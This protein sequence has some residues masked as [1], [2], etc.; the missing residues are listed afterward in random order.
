MG[1]PVFP[2]GDPAVGP[3]AAPTFEYVEGATFDGFLAALQSLYDATDGTGRQLRSAPVSPPAPS[4]PAPGHR[5]ALRGVIAGV[6]E[7]KKR[8]DAAGFGL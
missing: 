7:L 8:S 6:T 1:L 5:E 2:D 4:A 3:N